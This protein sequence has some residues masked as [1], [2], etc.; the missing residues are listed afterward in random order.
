MRSAT[1]N[2]SLMDKL[3][4]ITNAFPIRSTE[5][6]AILLHHFKIDFWF[7]KFCI[8]IV[9]IVVYIYNLKRNY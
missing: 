1:S 5:F 3:T 8:S 7:N 2:D 9:V 4:R 6:P